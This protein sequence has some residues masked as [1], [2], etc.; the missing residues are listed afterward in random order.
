MKKATLIISLVAVLSLQSFA[1]SKTNSFGI[2][3]GPTFDWASSGSTASSNE[4]MRMGFVVGGVYD[5]NLNNYFALSS[6]INV[7]F[8][9][10]HYQ[11]SDYRNIS[12]FLEKMQIK[13]DRRVRSTYVTIPLAAKAKVHIIDGLKAFAIVGAD[14]G[15]NVDTKAKD[16]YDLYWV[17]Y[18]DDTFSDEYAEQYRWLQ[19]AL[20]FGLGAE[21][22]I[23][24]QFSAF[25]QLSFN[26]ALTNSFNR[27]MARETESDIKTN[28]I[29]IEVGIMY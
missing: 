22:Q 29:G 10:G 11:F 20:D 6:G 16:K 14:L 28:F 3:F 7:N 5:Y 2:K 23:N 8:W 1:Q 18:T 9:R 12:N 4:G 24:K 13:A 15:V 25:A 26:H 21:Y 17:T 19:A 27:A